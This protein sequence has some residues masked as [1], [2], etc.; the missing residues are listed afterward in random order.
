M[1]RPC[2][3]EPLICESETPSSLAILFASGLAFTWDE[4]LVDDWFCWGCNAIGAAATFSSTFCGAAGAVL[5]DD[6]ETNPSKTFLSSPSSRMSAMQEFTA[7]FSVPSATKIFPKIPS[8]T[9][10]T[11]MVA[12]SVSISAITSPALILSPSFLT[13]FARFPSFIVGERA[14]MRISIGMFLKIYF[15][16]MSRKLFLTDKK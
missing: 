10:S 3:P 2:G 1:T 14:G 11:S 12:L 8:S 4:K 6:L 15:E 13:H 5:A 9:A 16:E 7:T